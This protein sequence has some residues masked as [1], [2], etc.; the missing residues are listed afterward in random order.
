MCGVHGVCTQ[1]EMW[2]R[3]DNAEY[4]F[5]CSC[6]QA[7]ALWSND[8]TT[9]LTRLSDIFLVRITIGNIV[10]GAIFV[11]ELRFARGPNVLRP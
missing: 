9:S 11:T 2:Q 5:S 7:G 4:L 3:R 10:I 8:P 6:R 1:R